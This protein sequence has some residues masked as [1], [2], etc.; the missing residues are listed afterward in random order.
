MIRDYENATVW[1][2]LFLTTFPELFIFGPCIS[3][4][5]PKEE[6]LKCTLRAQEHGETVSIY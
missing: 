3:Q 1:I 4:N 2:C 6:T 5:V